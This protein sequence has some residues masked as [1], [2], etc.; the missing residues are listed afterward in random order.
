MKETATDL[1]NLTRAK[2]E[3]HRDRRGFGWYLS[4]WVIC[5]TF[6]DGKTVELAKTDKALAHYTKDS[7]LIVSG[8]RAAAEAPKTWEFPLINVRSYFIE[9][10]AQYKD[11]PAAK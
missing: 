9:Q 5:I 2:E 6:M 10:R 11:F 1:I 7:V 4:G 8:T 3:V